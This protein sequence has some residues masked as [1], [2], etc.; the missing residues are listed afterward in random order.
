MSRSWIAAGLALIL[1]ASTAT[2]DPAADFAKAVELLNKRQL[3]HYPKVIRLFRK[4]A[5][6]ER[7]PSTRELPIESQAYLGWMEAD[8]RAHMAKV[9]LKRGDARRAQALYK[10]ILTNDAL[11]PEA[12]AAIRGKLKEAKAAERSGAKPKPVDPDAPTVKTLTGRAPVEDTIAFAHPGTGDKFRISYRERFESSNV[13]LD[14]LDK[15]KPWLATDEGGDL[16]RVLAR[17]AVKKKTADDGE[18]KDKPAR[19]RRGVIDRPLGQ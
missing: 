3:K 16:L 11:G 9:A 14:T 18:G 7:T 4:V 1:G 2:A 19:P 8:V 12:K 10:Q 17:G 5:A 6:I 15:A 13:F